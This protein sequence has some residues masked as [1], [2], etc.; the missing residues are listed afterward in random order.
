MEAG[1]ILACR[2]GALVCYLD[3]PPIPRTTSGREWRDWQ[4]PLALPRSELA[5]ELKSIWIYTKAAVWDRLEIM[6]AAIAQTEQ[7]LRYPVG[8]YR[9]PSE[10]DASTRARWITELAALPDRIRDAVS[11]LSDSQLD[12]PYRPDGWTVRQVVHHL[13]DSHLNSYQR[14][15]L[16]LTEDNPLIKPYEEQLWAELSDAKNAPVEDSLLLLKGLHRRWVRLLESLDESQWS[17]T[18]RH[19]AL[20][21]N[22]LDWTLGLYA[23]HSR[24]HTAHIVNLRLRQDW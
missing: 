21:E 5:L 6:S 17:R 14:F 8:R 13:P 4:K 19:P 24:H 1:P 7:S 9:A 10:I 20:G 23:W 12:T 11:G 2:P 15:R 22:R 18:F 3:L 16:A